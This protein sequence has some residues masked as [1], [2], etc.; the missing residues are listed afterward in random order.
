MKE[1]KAAAPAAKASSAKG[2]L[3]S[4]DEL[5]IAWADVILPT[6]APRV[7]S[8]YAAGRFVAASEEGAQMAL[9]N[10]PHLQRCAELL[11]V[12]REALAAHFGCPVPVELTVEADIAA[13]PTD[14][15]EAASLG[16]S[17]VTDAASTDAEDSSTEDVGPL[18]ELVDAGRGDLL[19][20]RIGQHF[21]GAEEVPLGA[22][23]QS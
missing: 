22:E 11:P 21:P 19:L 20:D 14:N 9:P 17:D 3:P 10:E 13:P 4:R 16:G 15:A 7:R 2:S 18:D 6:L 8:R 23:D 5:T 1:P 12:V